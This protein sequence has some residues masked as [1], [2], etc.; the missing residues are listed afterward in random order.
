MK[1]INISTW[2]SLATETMRIFQE[3]K[4]IWLKYWEILYN[5]IIQIPIWNE[6][7]SRSE[8]LL[9]GDYK[10]NYKCFMNRIQ[11]VEAKC[12]ETALGNFIWDYYFKSDWWSKGTRQN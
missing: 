7:G 11:V 12:K 3:N 10:Q 2:A 9:K 1:R 4:G 5:K 8:K 6:I